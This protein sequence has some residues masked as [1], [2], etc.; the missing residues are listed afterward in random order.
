ME[1]KPIE[2]GDESVLHSIHNEDE[3]KEK[4]K[5]KEK[6]EK[7]LNPKDNKL[8]KDEKL[9]EI[10]DQSEGSDDEIA[11]ETKQ[12]R[13]WMLSIAPGKQIQF[14]MKF[15]PKEVRQYLFNVPLYL[16]SYGAL[17]TL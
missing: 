10:E 15:S 14:N 6:D 13:Y 4:D 8:K 5:E 12:T 11:V 7:P 16:K 3:E 17:P 9:A 1:V 2:D